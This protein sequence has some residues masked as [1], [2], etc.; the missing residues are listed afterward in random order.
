LLDVARHHAVEP[1]DEFFQKAGFHLVF[2]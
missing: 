1:R 2:D